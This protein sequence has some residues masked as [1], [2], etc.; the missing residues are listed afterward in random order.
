MTD[1][2]FDPFA[3]TEH[4]EAAQPVLELDGFNILEAANAPSCD[5]CFWR[6]KPA[7]CL[8]CAWCHNFEGFVDINDLASV[9]ENEA[10]WKEMNKDD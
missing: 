6:T 8:F 10:M 3:H 1:E 4:T 7:D 9:K 2:L 5:R